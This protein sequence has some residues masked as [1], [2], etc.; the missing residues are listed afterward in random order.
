MR[1]VILL[2]LLTVL[3]NASYEKAK[4]FYEEGAYEQAIAEAK[5]STSEYSNPQLHLVWAESEEA[6]GNTKE[7]MS[8]YERVLMLDETQ[9]SVRVKLVAIYSKSGRATLASSMKES[10]NNYQLT[11][12]QRSSLELLEKQTI[13]TLKAKGSLALGYDSNINVSALSE[14]LEAYYNTT[15]IEGEVS[16]LFS[17]VNASVSYINDFETKGGWYVRGDVKLYYQNNFDANLYNMFIGTLEGGVGYAGSGYTLYFPLA[18]ERVHYLD[19]DML[20]AVKLQPKLNIT[21]SSN[22]I[23]NLNVKYASKTYQE[24]RYE[25]MDES[26]YGGGAGVY[27][28]FGENF[29]YANFMYEEFSAKEDSSL[30]FVNKETF[31]S[32]LG[33]NYNV[34][35][36]FTT[37]LDY[38]Y[39]KA[40]YEDGIDALTFLGAQ[41]SDSF[42]QVELKLSHYFAKHYEAFVLGKYIENTSNYIPAEYSKNIAMF[43]LSANY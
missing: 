9:S 17:R 20:G 38:R 10:L 11:P 2:S 28:L 19:V 23:V 14:D 43:G 5:A 40:D 35:N 32:S 26:S 42:N 24:R 29:L 25:L 37:R 30:A 33:V 16:T 3:A 41:R 7:A 31:T 1:A 12:A 21:L 22:V 13:T 4:E 15:A 27:Y 8:A 18:Y 6:L 36:L 34:A 39:R